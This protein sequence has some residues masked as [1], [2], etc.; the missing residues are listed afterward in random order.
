MNPVTLWHLFF[1]SAGGLL[2]IV[3][4]GLCMAGFIVWFDK[5]DQRRGRK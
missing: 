5:R 1:L 3:I 4:V 2:A